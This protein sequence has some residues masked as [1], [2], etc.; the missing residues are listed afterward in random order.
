VTR[1]GLPVGPPPEELMELPL[2][3]GV[4]ES[5]FLRPRR[6]TR[7]RPRRRAFTSRA[8][9][10]AQVAAVALLAL[11]GAWTAW[12]RVFASDRLRVGRL[13]VRGSHFLSEGEVRELASPVVGESILALDIEA[14]KAR[15]RSSPW[16]ADA[17]VSRALPDTVRVEIHERVPLALAEL[18]RLYL[19]DEDGGLI[20]IYG[21]RTGAFDLPI[22]RGLLGVEEESRRDRARRAGTLLADLAELGSEISE[23][24]V[25]PSGDLRV[26]LRGPGE[27]LLFGDPP[28]REKL[29]T[30][31]SLRRDLAEKAPGAEQ[32]DLRFRGRIFARQPAVKTR[33][34]E[35]GAVPSLPAAE[36]PKPAA[37]AAEPPLARTTA[38]LHEM[39]A[40]PTG[41]DRPG[42]FEKPQA[43]RGAGFTPEPRVEG[44]GGA[45]QHS[46]NKPQ[47][48]RGAGF[49]PEPRAGGLGGAAQHPPE[50]R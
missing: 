47:A 10:G 30:F 48:A 7:V 43:A 50:Q 37:H 2:D 24:Y 17:T 32:F 3:A 15:L 1:R 9:L 22:V 38:S 4:E 49:T 31:L 44:L 41:Q 33:P 46:A 21:P 28:Y 11:A 6:R 13:E 18:D 34:S 23:V 40:W 19:M 16:V 26:V 20:D 42:P 25:E 35:P 5:P 27:V 29:V 8:L 36:P 45:P 39:P 14:L 12:Q